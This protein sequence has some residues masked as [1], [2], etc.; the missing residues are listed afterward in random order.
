M[1]G[2]RGLA[3]NNEAD[4]S[5]FQL[6]KP[7]V[8]ADPYPIY[9]RIRER[10][11]VHWDPFMHSWVVTS[12]AE[13]VTVL[14]KYKAAR[15]PTPEQ[16][17]MMGLSVLRPYAET[18]L[19]QMLFMDAPTHTRLR[20]MCAQAFTAKRMELLRQRCE[21]IANELIDQVVDHGRLDLIRDFASPFPAIVLAALMGV[22]ARDREQLKRWS[23]DFSELLGNFEHNPDRVRAL[24]SSLEQMQAYISDQ[25][26][27]QRSNP[28][29]GVISTLL[30]VEMDGDLLTDEEVVANSM[31]M[32]AGGLEETTNLIGNG[33]FSLLQRPNEF[34]LLKSHPEII[35][36]AIEE[37]LR[38]ESPTQHTGRIAPEDVVL[39]GKRISKGS[40]L[41]AVVAAANR[42]PAR[43]IDP[44]RLDLERKDNRHVAFGWASHYCLGAPLSRLAGQIA[45][46]VLLRRLPGLA[47]VTTHPEWRGMAA[48]RGILSLDVTFDVESATRLKIGLAVS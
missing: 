13:V 39:G 1:T 8:V 34:A 21:Q 15:T 18:M 16:L 9:R 38:F 14:S 5:L 26:I 28:R 33:M 3:T 46:T 6:L 17:E 30:S 41:I 31:L 44:D 20:N 10:E 25:V 11:P 4:Y 32:I 19:K 35:Q 27:E 7:E 24:V 12:Y 45:F 42:D 36:S 22:P 43:F 29:D 37:L 40:A 48:M 47:L 23:S 2:S